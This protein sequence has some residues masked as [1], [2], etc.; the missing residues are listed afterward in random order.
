M[1]PA[2]LAVSAVLLLAV[3]ALGLL[4]FRPR[5]RKR[6]PQH[7]RAA[8]ESAGGPP[9]AAGSGGSPPPTPPP[10]PP[11]PKNATPSAPSAPLPAIPTYSWRPP[12]PSGRQAR[13]RGGRRGRKKKNKWVQA[14]DGAAEVAKVS[15]RAALPAGAWDGAAWKLP[16][17]PWRRQRDLA[18]DVREVAQHVEVVAVGPGRQWAVLCSR[19]TGGPGIARRCV[20]HQ[21]KC[22]ERFRVFVYNVSSAPPGPGYGLLMMHAALRKGRLRNLVTAS[23]S[24][25]CGFV[26][27]VDAMLRGCRPWQVTD[28]EL[29]HRHHASSAPP[30]AWLDPPPPPGLL[31]TVVNRSGRASLW[32]LNHFAF[33]LDDQPTEM[34]TWSHWCASYPLE[35]MVPV[36]GESDSHHFLPWI[37]VPVGAQRQSGA[38]DSVRDQLRGNPASRRPLLL[39]FA[40]RGLGKEHSRWLLLSALKDQSKDVGVFLFCG[41]GA[42]DPLD[43]QENNRAAAAGL[44]FLLP[45]PRGNVAPPLHGTSPGFVQLL[46]NSTFCLVTRGTALYQSRLAEALWAGCIPVVV[47]P[48]IKGDY[49]TSKLFLDNRFIEERRARGEPLRAVLPLNDTIDWPRIALE[50]EEKE[51]L[52]DPAAFVGRLRRLKAAAEQVDTMQRLGTAALDGVIDGLDNV[53]EEVLRLW[54]WRAVVFDAY[55]RKEGVFAER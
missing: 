48:S 47:H 29:L 42:C 18:A 44:G 37:D 30:A 25:A 20:V 49:F 2:P 12:A 10:L 51:V 38:P 15:Q 3:I 26:L 36:R 19:R 17:E 13:M 50:V 22:A 55:L 27:G 33:Q 35:G 52:D 34:P 28:K 16:A 14:G 32:G 9:P 1:R 8:P 7:R 6:S 24:E 43:L 53:L 39:F 40:G 41:G 5:R 4:H 31:E 11:Q 46:G 54:R 21:R 45:D 23:P